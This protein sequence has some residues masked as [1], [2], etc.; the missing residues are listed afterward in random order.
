MSDELVGSGIGRQAPCE[1]ETVIRAGDDLLEGVVEDCA[2][3]LLLMA[4]ESL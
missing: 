1:D 4:L 2:S 3:N